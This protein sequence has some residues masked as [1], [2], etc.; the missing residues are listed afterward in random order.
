MG[1]YDNE[2]S[3]SLSKAKQKSRDHHYHKNRKLYE[4]Y[5]SGKFQYLMSFSDYK[6]KVKKRKTT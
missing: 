4:E 5:T 2:T 3:R 1:G 6:K